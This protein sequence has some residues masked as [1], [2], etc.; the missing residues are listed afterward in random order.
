[1]SMKR[2]RRFSADFKAR[3]ALEALRGVK[4]LHEIAAEY[5][6]HPVQ[7]SQWERQD[8]NG[9]RRLE[10]DENGIP[11]RTTDLMKHQVALC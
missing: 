5:G 9:W 11:N 10:T 6:V 7:V 8:Q 3:V 1:M 2:R 4:T